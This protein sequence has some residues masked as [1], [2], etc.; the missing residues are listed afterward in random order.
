MI[1]ALEVKSLLILSIFV[2]G[3]VAQKCKKP[4]V[5][6]FTTYLLQSRVAWILLSGQCR[7]LDPGQEVPLPP[8]GLHLGHQE[9][10]GMGQ[11]S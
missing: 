10:R 6:T 8:A 2:L 7:G 5:Q 4:K 9:G 1:M 11:V 3:I